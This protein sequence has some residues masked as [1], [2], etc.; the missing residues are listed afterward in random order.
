MKKTKGMIMLL[1]LMAALAGCGKDKAE[2]TPTPT[3]ETTQVP[4][5]TE[6]A[7]KKTEEPEATQEPKIT[8]EPT[9]AAKET[10]IPKED[11]SN[12]KKKK[13]EAM[14]PVFDS[15]IR[16][17]NETGSKYAPRD[18]EYFW[19]T[20]YLMG[21][22]YGGNNSLVEKEE[23]EY[24]V[25]RKVMQEYASACF[26]DYDDLLDFPEECSIQYS[27]DYDAYILQLSDKGDLE[28]KVTSIEESK[29]GYLVTV[30]ASG[31]YQFTIVD[32]PYASG[33]ADPAFY[34]TVKDCVKK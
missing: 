12:S 7:D 33:I 21:V 6:A 3:A 4:T 1:L 20:L 23:F 26:L 28:V 17:M 18:Q 16:A 9:E 13:I 24:K 5:E 34:Y 2:T 25:P 15:L 11:V 10:Q 14:E 19:S 27:E 8:Q 22:N 31:T 30:T 32:N 29:E